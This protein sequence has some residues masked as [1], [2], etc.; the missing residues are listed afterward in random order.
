MMR[1]SFLTIHMT[2]LFGRAKMAIL[3]VM[4][5]SMRF[6]R[7]IICGR[8]TSSLIS[9]KSS[10]VRGAIAEQ[11]V[12]ISCSYSPTGSCMHIFLKCPSAPTKKVTGM[13]LGSLSCVSLDMGIRFSGMTVTLIS[14]EWTG[15]TVWYFLLQTSNSINTLIRRLTQH[16]ILRQVLVA[17][18]THSQ[19]QTGGHCLVWSRV[20]KERYQL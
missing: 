7:E 1:P 18:G 14:P 6:G 17:L 8:Q 15:S 2:S 11:A 4:V 5:I 16:G 12:L 13:G 3:R 9:P 10:S 20:K 19:Q